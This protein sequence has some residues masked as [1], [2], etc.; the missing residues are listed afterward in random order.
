MH[1]I[2]ETE[3]DRIASDTG[4]ALRKEKQY[5][6]LISGDGLG[7]YW[8]GGINGHIFR[9]RTGITV[10]VPESLYRLIRQNAAV[11]QAAALSAA[12]YKGRGRKVG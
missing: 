6:I 10:T 11:T 8:E 4:D 5:D 7:A 12:P 9:I 1:Y 2:T 3:I